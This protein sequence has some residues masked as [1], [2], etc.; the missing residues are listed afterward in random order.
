MSAR[1]CDGTG[2]IERAEADG[3]PRAQAALGDGRLPPLG[4]LLVRASFLFLVDEGKQLVVEVLGH[5]LLSVLGGKGTG[6]EG[7]TVQRE[8]A[9][10]FASQPSLFPKRLKDG[11]RPPPE[12]AR[13]GPVRQ[14]IPARAQLPARVRVADSFV[15]L[16]PRQ[17]MSTRR[18]AS[19]PSSF[20]PPLPSWTRSS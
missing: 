19:S 20:L 17:S 12:P 4:L 3:P 14:S 16:F 11:C 15:G 7:E 18:V 1:C 9:K 6:Q 5:G 13:S 10:G 2:A 8:R